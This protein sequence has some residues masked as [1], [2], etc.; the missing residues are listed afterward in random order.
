[1]KK[2]QAHSRQGTGKHRNC[3]N[4]HESRVNR[5]RSI[6]HAL[7]QAHEEKAR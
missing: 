5:N 4:N 1:M 6:A 2:S 3:Y 7:K